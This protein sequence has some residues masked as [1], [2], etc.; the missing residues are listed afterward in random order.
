[1]GNTVSCPLFLLLPFEFEAFTGVRFIYLL[2][3]PPALMG[4]TQKM[5]FVTVLRSHVRPC[6]SNVLSSLPSCATAPMSS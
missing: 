3:V 4:F 5:E 1:M 2:L 6:A